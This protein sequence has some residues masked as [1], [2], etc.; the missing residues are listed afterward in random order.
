MHLPTF[1]SLALGLVA[2]AWAAPS[3]SPLP[4]LP[5]PVGVAAPFAG[6]PGGVLV[7]AGGANFPA[8]PPWDG[9]KKVWHDTIWVL[10]SPS[11]PWR[12]GGALPQPRAYGVS[13][14]HRDRLFCVGGSDATHHTAEVVGLRWRRGRIEPVAPDDLPPPLPMPMA[15]G[16][17]VVDG[18]GMAYVACG[19]T[20]P[21]ERSASGKVFRLRLGTRGAAWT[22]L[23]PIPAEP[24][25]L[26]VI[27]GLPEGFCLIGGAALERNAGKP[28]R[29]Y[30]RDVWRYH[31]VHGWDR[32]PDLPNP[33]VAAA[34][35]APVDRNALYV[36]GGDDGS[37]LGQ[38]AGPVHPGFSRTLHRL[39]LKILEWTEAGVLPAPRVTLPC[40]AWNGGW[41]FPSGEVQPGIR[42]PEV[43]HLRLR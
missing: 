7:V 37:R 34:S 29:R 32:L 41:I 5:D 28:V 35:P 38:P 3:W 42:S 31:P 6:T 36:A 19:S 13:L 18:R 23:P 4:P 17:G 8:G 24:R 30:L 9:G 22:E 15:N 25:I 1:W 14:T 43:W 20:E 10:S 40:V 11:G 26:P 33:S 27:A 39:D 21:G 12:K 16:A 2:G